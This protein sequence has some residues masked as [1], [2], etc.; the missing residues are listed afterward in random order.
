[1]APKPVLKRPAVKGRPRSLHLAVA[2]GS[3]QRTASQP[4]QAAF[5]KEDKCR[6]I[7]DAVATADWLPQVVR[8]M[9]AYLVFPGFA[10]EERG[11]HPYQAA[12][13]K[14]VRETLASI[15]DSMV[16]DMETAQAAIDEADSNKRGGEEKMS[17]AELHLANMQARVI[18][19]K[20]QLAEANK[21]LAH[22]AKVLA[23]KEARKKKAIGNA[24]SRDI[25]LER[26]QLAQ[27]NTYLPF[28]EAAAKGV[29]GGR[30]LR[31]LRKV[32]KE[33][34]FHDILL[35]S[36]PDVLRKTPSRRQTFDHMA[37][38]QLEKEFVKHVELAQ[39]SVEASRQ[40]VANFEDAVQEAQKL[41]A[42]VAGRQTLA[43]R[44]VDEAGAAVADAKSCVESIRS[45]LE[46]LKMEMLQAAHTLENRKAGLESFRT[47]PLAAFVELEGLEVREAAPMSSGL[48][49]TKETL[50]AFSVNEMEEAALQGPQHGQVCKVGGQRL[51]QSEKTTRHCP[52]SSATLFLPV[53]ETRKRQRSTGQSRQ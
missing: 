33:F 46:N 25:C 42:A 34:G 35:H 38:D 7:A 23:C 10:T 30:S 36:V 6:L 17:M 2:L 47:G 11:R 14:M 52:A 9:L 1:M 12:A 18:E 44:G 27:H 22:S 40:E 29:E 43:A 41:H 13:L 21:A 20:E 39:H 16:K 5:A 53:S 3:A 8:S 31:D 26:L 50:A 49:E 4:A 15:E 28:K 51:A 37:L 45:H 32:G 19:S 24:A 48:G